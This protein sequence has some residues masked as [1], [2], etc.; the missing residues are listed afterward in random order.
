MT[1]TQFKEEFYE[2]RHRIQYDNHRNPEE[3]EFKYM[4]LALN[5]RSYYEL[6][7]DL[8]K[9]SNFILSVSHT[10]G[11]IRQIVMEG[12]VIFI[13]EGEWEGIWTEGIP[14]EGSVFFTESG[15]RGDRELPMIQL[16]T[17]PM[18]A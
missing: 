7:N 5:F 2:H 17:I 14:P 6:M 18:R 10:Y 9:E 16:Q 13:V 11:F 15:N 4:T 8:V 3:K 12:C 1:G